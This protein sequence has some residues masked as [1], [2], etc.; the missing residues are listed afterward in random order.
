MSL[1]STLG[2]TTLGGA[3]VGT[4]V[5]T[6]DDNGINKGKRNQ[7]LATTLTTTASVIA[8]EAVSQRGIKEIHE[9]YSQAY[10]DSLTDEELEAALQQVNLLLNDMD[11][12]T[13]K[14]I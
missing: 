3:S 2:I 10:I 12:E 13:T 14:T 11:E 4:T 5:Y 8:S 9:K 1:M 6:I 7:V